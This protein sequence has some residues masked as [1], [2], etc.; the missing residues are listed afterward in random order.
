MSPLSVPFGKV[1]IDTIYTDNAVTAHLLATDRFEIGP[2]V[3][4][5]VYFLFQGEPLPEREVGN[6]IPAAC[7]LPTVSRTI[8]LVLAYAAGVLLEKVYSLLRLKGEPS[9]IRFVARELSTTHWFD[10][11][12]TRRNFGYQIRPS[13]KRG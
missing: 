6:R 11:D 1:F 13:L 2:A 7:G 5:K 10:M 4:G 8:L 3:A 9:M 12:A